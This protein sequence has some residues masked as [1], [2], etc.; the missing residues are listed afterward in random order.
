M[1]PVSVKRHASAAIAASLLWLGGTAGAVVA[2]PVLTFANADLST[3]PYSFSFMGGNFTLTGTGGFPNYL[4]VSTSG[5]AAVRTVFGN[6]STD[7]VD[8][9]IVVYDAMTLGGYGAFAAPTSIPY[10]TGD[11]FLG[12]R[13]TSGGQNF[14]GF[15]FST[16]SRL[17]SY[18]FE[19]APETGIVATAQ[20]SAAVPE[21]ASWAMMV[22]GFGVVG[23]AIRRRR[24]TVRFA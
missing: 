7:F 12:L 18:G 22:A 3:A 6:P 16:N 11:N 13:V 19:T 15:L 10:T 8:R 14:Y 17:N 24:V 9:S 4:A 21:A 23:A 2:A 1:Y 20:T 5:N